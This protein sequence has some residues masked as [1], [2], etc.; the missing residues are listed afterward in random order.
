[1]HSICMM[2]AILV[3]NLNSLKRYLN[4]QFHWFLLTIVYSLL[5][6]SIQEIMNNLN[7]GRY[8]LDALGPQNSHTD[9]VI[10]DLSLDTDLG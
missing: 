5:T 7:Q 3:L 1:M 8:V 10:L 4:S 6:C 2:F 9:A